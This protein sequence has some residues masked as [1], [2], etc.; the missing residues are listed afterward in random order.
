MNTP[1]DSLAPDA[2]PLRPDGFDFDFAVKTPFRMQPGLRRLAADHPGL[3]PTRPGSRHQREKLA[4][5]TALAADALLCETGFDPTPALVGLM[6]HAAR[7][8]PHAWAWDGQRAEA[9]LLGAAVDARG[10]V[11]PVAQGVFGLGDEVTRC[12]AGLPPVW[13]VAGLL[14]LAFEEDL[15]IVDADRGTLPWM[16][17]CLPS[18]WAP[19]DKIGRSFAAAHEPVADNRMLLAASDSLMRL[20]AGAER[21][22]RFVWTITPHSRLHG[23]PARLDPRGWSLTPVQHAWWRTEHQCFLPVRT[24]EGAQA[25][26]T[27]RVAL[28]RL[29]D[30]VTTPARARALHDALAS[31]SEAVRRYRQLEDVA[32]ALLA[33]LQDREA[34]PPRTGSLDP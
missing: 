21:W 34:R 16:A 29:D 27:I 5:L 1:D 28:Q 23:H 20:V 8:L 13:R 22:E 17:V 9:R 26:F 33:W 6:E 19:A 7:T 32:P 12:L 2:D 31:Q 24:T 10:G 3:T 15:A 30:A 4:V 14:A 11:E 18:F 25:V